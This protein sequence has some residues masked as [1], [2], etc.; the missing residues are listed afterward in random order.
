VY[1]A[2]NTHMEYE[3]KTVENLENLTQEEL[4][5]LEAK[6]NAEIEEEEEEAE[7]TIDY[8]AKAEAAE[9]RAATL[10]RLLNKKGGKTINKTNTVDYSQD[11]LEIKQNLRIDSFAEENGLTKAQARKVF[12]INS[13]PTSELLKDPFISEGLKAIAR[14]ERVD[15][16]T[17]AGGRATTVNGKSFKEMTEEDRRANYSKLMQG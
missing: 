2:Y 16:A 4:D 5:A 17:P 7:P 8:K 15:N 14:K 11:I 1:Q 6:Q 10:Q 12:E 9:R 3:D 13:N